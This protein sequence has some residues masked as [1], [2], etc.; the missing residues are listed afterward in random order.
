MISYYKYGNNKIRFTNTIMYVRFI[1]IYMS[2]LVQI[3]ENN[4][5]VTENQ[6]DKWF[7]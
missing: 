6:I 2:L 4:S 1:T 5:R 3:M 7:L